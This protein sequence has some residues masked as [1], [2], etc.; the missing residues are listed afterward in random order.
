[1]QWHEKHY[2][3]IEYKG[4]II[5]LN[6]GLLLMSNDAQLTSMFEGKKILDCY[7]KEQTEWRLTTNL[8]VGM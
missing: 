6:A 5:A 3:Q 1:M 4:N 7:F 2:E 8:R